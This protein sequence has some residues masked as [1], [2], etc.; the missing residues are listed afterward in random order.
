MLLLGVV[1]L[2]VVG[3]RE[4]PSLLRTIGQYVGKIR[5]IASEF[6]GQIDDMGRDISTNVAD[7]LAIQVVIK[8]LTESMQ[9]VDIG[10]PDLFD[11]P[12]EK[13]THG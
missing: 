2:L 4:L 10:A 3:P 7:D 1:V 5:Q 12:D 9:E 6:R 13:D 8:S 11:A